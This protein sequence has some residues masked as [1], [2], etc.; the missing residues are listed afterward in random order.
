MTFESQSAFYYGDWYYLD[1]DGVRRRNPRWAPDG[2]R[3]WSGAEPGCQEWCHD[4]RS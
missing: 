3:L 1:A 2:A 4:R